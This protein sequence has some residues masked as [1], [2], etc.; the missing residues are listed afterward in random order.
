MKQILLLILFCISLS[1][2][3]QIDFSDDF[4]VTGSEHTIDIEHHFD[5]KNNT[6]IE[7][8]SYWEL[9]LGEDFPEEWSTFLC[10]N[11]L[12]YTP[13]TRKCPESN[14]NIFAP[15]FEKEWTLHVKPSGTMGTGQLTIRM[16]YPQEAGDSTFVD[17]VFDIS[18]GVSNTIELDLSDLLI[19]PNPTADYIQI[20]NDK[21]IGQISVYNVVGKLITE[22][23]HT[24][25]QSHSV[26]DLNRGIY[27]VRLKDNT[28]KVVK[29]M[30]LSKS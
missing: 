3:A 24:E 21:G 14:P 10:D 11:N 19:Y 5:V 16:H 8:T 4:T 29:S 23:N 9:I 12:C 22:F 18:I 20:T 7:V 13:W 28:G 17:H 1:A 2:K 27:L 25:G 15:G 30:K 6:D 26:A